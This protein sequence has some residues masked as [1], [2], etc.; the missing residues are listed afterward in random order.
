VDSRVSF[1]GTLA[2]LAASAFEG[3]W[4][5]KDTAGGPF[6]IALSSGG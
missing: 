1:L 2:G 4:K 5:I 6:E 3:V